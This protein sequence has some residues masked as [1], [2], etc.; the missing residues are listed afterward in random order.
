M[1]ERA[2]LPPRLPDWPERLAGYLQACRAVPFAW[3]TQDCAT[4]AAGAVSAMTG[5]RLSQL[6]P[7]TWGNDFEAARAVHLAGGLEQATALVLGDPI[8]GRAARH[9][10]RGSVVLVTIADRPTLGIASGG[11]R[12]CGPGQVGLVWRPM[13]EVR[14]AWEI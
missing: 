6:L 13:A 1:L 4:F 8:T 14:T 3:G 9:A 12:W 7:G 11:Q 2:T 5:C 10:C